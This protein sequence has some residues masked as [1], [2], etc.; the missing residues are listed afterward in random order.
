M[1]ARY[2]FSCRVCLNFGS[3]DIGMLEAHVRKPRVFDTSY[4]PNRS[5]WT[6]R[7]P[8]DSFFCKLCKYTTMV[9]S[10]T[11]T[12]VFI[13]AAYPQVRTIGF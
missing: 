9:S 4:D 12:V 6:T 10:L 1:S 5:E 8:D 2:V 11:A 13:A 3:D 7:L